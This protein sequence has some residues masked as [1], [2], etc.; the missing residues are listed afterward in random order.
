MK[1]RAVQHADRA[2]HLCWTIETLPD[3]AI[4]TLRALCDVWCYGTVRQ[5]E[6][7][8]FVRQHPDATICKQCL[9][10]AREKTQEERALRGMR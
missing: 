5:I 10:I 9:A 2:W 4:V 3:R 6:T 1:L 8:Q 7:R